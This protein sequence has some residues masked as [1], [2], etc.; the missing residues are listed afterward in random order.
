V[1]ASYKCPIPWIDVRG[2]FTST[3]SR[4]ITSSSEST[5]GSILMMKVSSRSF[6]NVSS[7]AVVVIVPEDWNMALMVKEEAEAHAGSCHKVG[8]KFL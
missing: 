4:A 1:T 2:S 6:K 8:S 7:I 5:F 3:S